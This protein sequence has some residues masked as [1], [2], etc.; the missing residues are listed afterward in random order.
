MFARRDMDIDEYVNTLDQNA[1]DELAA[2]IAQHVMQHITPCVLMGV[3]RGNLAITF[4]AIM[5]AFFLLSSSMERFEEVVRSVLVWCTG[6]G[7]ESG[8]PRVRPVPL[9]DVFP[10]IRGIGSKTKAPVPL[11]LMDD[12]ENDIRR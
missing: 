6:Y 12:A 2:S 1:E 11:C 7:I 9:A 10:C 5:H 4:Q 8:I 3:G